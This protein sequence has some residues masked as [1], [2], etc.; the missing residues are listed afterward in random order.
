MKVAVSAYK[1]FPNKEDLAMFNRKYRTN[2]FDRLMAA[3]TFAEAGERES[4]LE[5]MLQKLKKKKQK[6]I[7]PKTNRTD[8]TRPDM[9]I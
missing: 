6:W 9:R 1:R 4:A 8:S 5:V 3:V 2:K 7:G